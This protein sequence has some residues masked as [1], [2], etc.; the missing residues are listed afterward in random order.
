VDPEPLYKVT[1]KKNLWRRR[2]SCHIAL[3]AL[4][5]TIRDQKLFRGIPPYSHPYP[6]AL[7]TQPGTQSVLRVFVIPCLII[8]LLIDY[9]NICISHCFVGE[10]V[11]IGPFYIVPLSNFMSYHVRMCSFIQL[12][13]QEGAEL[14]F[15]NV[16]FQTHYSIFSCGFCYKINKTK[17]G[18][19]FLPKSIESSRSLE[20]RP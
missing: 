15:L 4:H 19:Q 2:E 5:V 20:W 3:E 17:M 12:D 11:M 7:H 6:H 14:I 10:C 9:S 13:Q 16:L 1:Q 18:H 8:N